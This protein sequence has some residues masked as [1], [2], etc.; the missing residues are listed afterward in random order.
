MIEVDPTNNSD[1]SYDTVA[2]EMLID[3]QRALISDT[4]SVSSSRYDQSVHAM[5]THRKTMSSATTVFDNPYLRYRSSM[6]SSNRVT[7]TSTSEVDGSQHIRNS[8]VL[9]Q[10]REGY[11][12]AASS[13]SNIALNKS[14]PSSENAVAPFEPSRQPSLHRQ[15][16][17]RTANSTGT[18]K[19]SNAIKRKVGWLTMLRQLIRKCK[20]HAAQKWRTIRQRRVFGGRKKLR[21]PEPTAVSLPTARPEAPPLN[22]TNTVQK[23][24]RASST[25]KSQREAKMDRLIR[26][27]KENLIDPGHEDLVA[28]WTSYLRSTVAKRIQLKLDITQLAKPAHAR[29]ASLLDSILSDYVSTGDSDGNSMA[30]EW[31]SISTAESSAMDE[32]EMA[33]YIGRKDSIFSSESPT[34]IIVRQNSVAFSF[35]PSVLSRPEISGRGEIFST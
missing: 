30:S 8:Q 31:S 11:E 17:T 7:L 22:R 6:R 15:L 3:N 23:L 27:S 13:H 28:L 16:T 10:L 18:L 33:D 35:A 4:Q 21:K 2:S 34:P 19:R 25:T 26:R 1:S 24:S 5:H 9:P 20:R 32:R 29:R 14:L 12:S